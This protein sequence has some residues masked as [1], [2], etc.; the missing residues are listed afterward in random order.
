[1][2]IFIGAC[3]GKEGGWD[4]FPSHRVHVVLLK[5]TEILGETLKVGRCRNCSFAPDNAVLGQQRCVRR[6][7]AQIHGNIEHFLIVPHGESGESTEQT[8]VL[9]QEQLHKL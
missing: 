8:Q 5:S 3:S 2:C 9:E 6:T 7:K 1:M 4:A